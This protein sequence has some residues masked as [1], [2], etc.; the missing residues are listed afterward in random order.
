MYGLSS[1]MLSIYTIGAI[2]KLSTAN[3]PH[4]FDKT[5]QKSEAASQ[6]R[7]TLKSRPEGVPSMLCR[8]Q[9]LAVHAG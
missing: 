8:Q 2:Y 6:D 4:L 5:V 9:G 1:A 3:M 7:L